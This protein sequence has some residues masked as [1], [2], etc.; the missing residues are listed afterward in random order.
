MQG[1]DISSYQAGIDLA[2]VPGGFVI[3]KA[4]QGTGYVN[5]DCGRAV[6]Q[7]LAAG[8]LVGVYHYIDGSEAQGEADF[9]ANQISG[10][11]GRVLICLDWEAG[12]N[13]RWGDLGYLGAVIDRVRERTGRPPVVYAS[14]AAFPWDVCA[15]RDCGAW[16]AQYADMTQTGYQDHPW[17]E[18]A[19]DCLIRQYSTTGRLPGWAGDLDLDIFYGNR[20]L[21]DAYVTGAGGAGKES[22]VQ[23]TDI[24]IR[25]DGHEATVQDVLSYIDM[26][27]ETLAGQMDDLMGIVKAGGITRRGD[28]DETG[29]T[30]L[31]WEVGWLP[32][33]FAAL[34]DLISRAAQREDVTALVNELQ[35]ARRAADDQA[36]QQ[37]EPGTVA[38]AALA[39][40]VHVVEAGETLKGI[41]EA[42]GTT[43]QA[44]VD[45]NPGLA[46]ND[47]V[48]GQRITVPTSKEHA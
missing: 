11:V 45:A 23:L 20:T 35:A 43:V 38:A 42:A 2:A 14:S 3:V 29:R 16:V 32:K 44:I 41:A 12:S 5:P 6:E 28:G 37:A 10:W 18:G 15:S 22:D 4:T 9:F 26:R 8:K 48:A 17:N 47:L 36:R 25:P 39:A 33:N 1:I 19:Y 7:A 46:P 27:C 34:Q 21:W 40:D 30:D 31:C 24:V 13:V